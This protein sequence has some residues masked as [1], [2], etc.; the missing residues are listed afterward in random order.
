MLKK[1]CNFFFLVLKKK[2]NFF[3]LLGPKY[4]LMV[5]GHLEIVVKARGTRNIIM[6][7]CTNGV[8]SK[9]EKIKKIKK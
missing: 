4:A 9:L 3:D 6:Y 5:K 8:A 2:K 1:K 7:V